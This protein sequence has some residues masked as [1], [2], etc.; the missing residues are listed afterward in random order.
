MPPKQP[1]VRPVSAAEAAAYL[2]KAKEFELAMLDGYRAERWTAA[3][4]AGIHAAISATD[5]VLGKLAGQR[6]AGEDHLMVLDFLKA[7]LSAKIGKGSLDDQLRRLSRILGIKN[8]VE[9]E[10]RSFC[11]K[12]CDGLV[13]DVSRYLDWVKSQFI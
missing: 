7:K 12:D 13:K 10:S 11:R 1:R 9:Y 4:L 6:S 3:A 5:A 2:D 8:L